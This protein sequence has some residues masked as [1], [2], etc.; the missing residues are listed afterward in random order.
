[1][2]LDL[3]LLLIFFV[4]VPL[5]QQYLQSKQQE[6]APRKPAPREPVPSVQSRGQ[7]PPTGAVQD[8]ASI[9][10]IVIAPQTVAPAGGARPPAAARRTQPADAP[11]RA[12]GGPLDLRRAVVLM[13]IL[14]PGRGVRPYSGPIDD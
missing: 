4:V 6:P 8:P 12:L 3:L 7:A 9:P 1:M 13:T 2:S 14:E 5:I 10:A 11:V